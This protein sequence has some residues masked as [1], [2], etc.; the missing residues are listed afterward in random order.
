ML[1]RSVKFNLPVAEVELTSDVGGPP[2]MSALNGFELKG[3]GEGNLLASPI[4]SR[5][6]G[7]KGMSAGLGADAFYMTVPG[8][9]P[10]KAGDRV[11]VYIDR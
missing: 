8:T 4:V 5:G 9:G 10:L 1:C 7:S 2:M 6:P 11:K 3:D